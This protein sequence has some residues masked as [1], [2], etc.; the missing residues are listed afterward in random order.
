MSRKI[1]ETEIVSLYKLK[2][3]QYLTCGKSSHYGQETFILQLENHINQVNCTNV[4]IQCVYMYSVLK[5]ISQ[6]NL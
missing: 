1:I 6:S 2:S 5:G 3:L 4:Y